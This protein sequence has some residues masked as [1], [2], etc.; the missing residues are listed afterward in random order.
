MRYVNRILNRYLLKQVIVSFVG[1]TAILMVVLIAARFMRYLGQ[2]AE[3]YL[4]PASVFT[5][6]HRLYGR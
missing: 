5:K 4:D 6:H 3:G 1:V 2:A